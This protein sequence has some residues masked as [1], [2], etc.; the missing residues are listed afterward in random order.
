MD[1]LQ[2][3][4]SQYCVA[5][6]PRQSM[7]ADNLELS[8]TGVRNVLLPGKKSP[9]S[10]E[11]K[12]QWRKQVSNL[13]TITEAAFKHGYDFDANSSQAFNQVI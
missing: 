9:V 5:E 13:W 2:T 1:I 8:W 12:I 7:K 4:K 3:Y 6:K 11:Q 10:K